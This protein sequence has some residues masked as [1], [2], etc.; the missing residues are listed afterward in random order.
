MENDTKT[1]FFKHVF[2][3]EGDAKSELLNICQYAILA[4]IPVIGL[5]K[6]LRHFTPEIDDRKSSFEIVLEVL[7]QVILIFMALLIIHR[8]ITYIPT[9]SGLEY[10]DINIIQIVLIALLFLFSLNTSIAEK[11]N[12]IVMRISDY[13]QGR[14]SGGK[15][16]KQGGGG[17]GGA[18]QGAMPIAM[19]QMPAAPQATQQ[20]QLPDYNN[21]Y[22]Q[23][24]TP[25]VGAASPGGGGGGGGSEGFSPM[26]PRELGPTLAQ[27][28]GGF[29]EPMAANAVLGGGSFGSAW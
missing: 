21:F 15:K 7:I 9:Y 12:I 29:G 24:T 20:Q 4:I 6:T 28:G 18:Q 5:N 17:N 2:G 19:P 16:K 1:S 22:T 8:V 14:Q 11:A 3:L 23:G 13:W 27:G 10:P 25:L 26:M